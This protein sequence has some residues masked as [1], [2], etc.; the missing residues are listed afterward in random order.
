M[1]VFKVYGIRRQVT[2]WF[3][4]I[5]DQ[6]AN[7][8]SIPCVNTWGETLIGRRFELTGKTVEEG[9]RQGEESRGTTLKS[10]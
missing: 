4:N 2:E 6:L 1:I 8:H 9:M 3:I 5:N 10:Q 7:Y